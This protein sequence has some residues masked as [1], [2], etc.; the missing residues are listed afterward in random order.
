MLTERHGE[1]VAIPPFA[2]LPEPM[3]IEHDNEHDYVGSERLRW[4]LVGEEILE[5][6]GERGFEPE[7]GASE[8]E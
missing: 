5:V 3:G 4:L 7:R 1:A 8:F 2:A 6:G